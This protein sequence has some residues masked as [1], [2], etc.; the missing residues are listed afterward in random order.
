MVPP[1]LPPAALCP[2]EAPL[3]DTQ[4]RDLTSVVNEMGPELFSVFN[5]LMKK[6]DGADSFMKL[7][8]HALTGGKGN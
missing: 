7:I 8:Y 1:P 4:D 3:Q 6:E 5:S 2:E